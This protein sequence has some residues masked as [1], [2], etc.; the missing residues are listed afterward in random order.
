MTGIP[1]LDQEHEREAFA[2]IL[3]TLIFL[4]T[5]SRRLTKDQARAHDLTG[6]QLTVIKLLSGIGEISLTELSENMQTKNS[7]V[8]GI[9]DRMESADLVKR[10]RSESDRRVIKIKLTSKGRALAKRVP[11]EPMALFRQALETLS[12][13]EAKTL[14]R[15]LSKLAD[16]VRASVAAQQDPTSTNLQ[17]PT[18]K[19]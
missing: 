7:T 9:I 8:T 11:I 19:A 16:H 15:I 12:S 6:P 18:L 4:Y 1:Q 17:D 2:R 14:L 13:H 5:E 10:S 3:E